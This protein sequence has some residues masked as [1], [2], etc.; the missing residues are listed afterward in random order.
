[1]PQVFAKGHKIFLTYLQ[2]EADPNRN[3][4]YLNM[5]DNSSE[6]TYLLALVELSGHTF[7]FEIAN[8]EVFSGLP[9]RDK[10]LEIYAAYVIKNSAWI[11]ELRIFTKFIHITMSIRG[12]T[13]I[14][15]LYCFMMKYLK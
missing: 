4:T 13:E 6:K 9:L 10:R 2:D 3:G 12:K 14:T 11:T 7:R 1:M 8:D 5:I 15:L